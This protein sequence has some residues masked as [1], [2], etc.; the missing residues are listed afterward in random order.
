M[1]WDTFTK[2]QP[3]IRSY[4]VI[5]SMHN[6]YCQEPSAFEQL[7][8][9]IGQRRSPPCCSPTSFKVSSYTFPRKANISDVCIARVDL[10]KQQKNKRNWTET[11]DKWSH[12]ENVCLCHKNVPR[13]H[14]L[15][16]LCV[17]PD[18]RH[19]YNHINLVRM[20]TAN[21]FFLLKL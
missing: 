8:C 14:F 11:K 18:Y 6:S 2:I 9:C 15:W 7:T 5:Q 19:A 4:S 17:C 16:R 21:V 20:Q 13:V 12:P 1:F 3:A 10:A